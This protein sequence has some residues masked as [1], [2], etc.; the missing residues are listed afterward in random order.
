MNLTD[1]FLINCYYLQLYGITINRVMSDA[2]YGEEFAKILLGTIFHREIGPLVVIPQ[3]VEYGI[4]TECHGIRLDVYMEEK[5]AGIFDMEADQN[6]S[7]K[8]RQ[9]L[10]KRVR[11][12]HAKIDAGVLESGGEYRDL[13]NVCVIFITTYDPFDKKRMVYTIKNCCTE[14]PDLP[15]EDGAR[16]IFLY[17]RGVNGNPPAD[18]AELLRYMEDTTEK[19]VCNESIRR[20]HEMVQHTKQ[21]AKAGLAYMKWYEI[22]T[23]CRE[24]GE[25]L[26]A[27]KMVRKLLQEQQTI[28]KIS[29]LTELPYTLI[30]KIMEQLNLHPEWDN[31]QILEKIE[32]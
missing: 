27:I 2:T 32:K 20:L 6:W 10:P 22:E 17:T 1:D 25:F 4:E 15:Y 21:D 8:D 26:F 14:E 3:K 24:E 29:Q 9:S 7:L 12:Y 16:T 30:E 31:E 19:N 13:R 28:D 18:L 11:L 23:M 5:D